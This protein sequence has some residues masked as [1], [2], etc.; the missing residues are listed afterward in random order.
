MS[1]FLSQK[2]LAELTPSELCPYPTPIPTQ[3]VSSDEYGV[4]NVYGDVGQL[5]ATTLV[6]QPR[7]CAALMGTLIKGL[8]VDHVCWG[9]D[10]LW[11]GSPQL[12][13]E[14]CAGWRSPKRC[15]RSS[16]L[17]VVCFQC[18]E[19]VAPEFQTGLLRLDTVEP[20]VVAAEDRSLYRPLSI[21]TGRGPAICAT[22]TS[23]VRS[24]MASLPELRPCTRCNGSA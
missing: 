22:A 20:R 4:N 3:I 11:T 19:T 5:F 13:I 7:V 18:G 16:A 12:Q 6:P 15:K 17:L 8:G 2:D 10:A 1:G 21:A 24:T 23:K 9:T 14:A